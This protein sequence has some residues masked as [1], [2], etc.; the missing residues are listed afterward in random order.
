GDRL[1]GALANVPGADG[2]FRLESDDSKTWDNGAIAALFDGHVVPEGFQSF[3]R[4]KRFKQFVRDAKPLKGHQRTVLARLIGN[5]KPDR[6]LQWN[7]EREDARDAF[8]NRIRETLSA[9][10]KVSVDAPEK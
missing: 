3:R 8:F 2:E 6:P 1:A 4:D 5:M 10:A 9:A 7:Y